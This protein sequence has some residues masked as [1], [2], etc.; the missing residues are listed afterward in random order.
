MRGI[1]LGLFV[2]VLI[3][4]G[5]AAGLRFYRG[6]REYRFLLFLFGC[7]V[8]LYALLFAVLPGDLGFLR[9]PWREP[10]SWVDFT[11]GLLVLSMLFHGFWGY[12]YASGIGPSASTMIEMGRRG[13]EMKY[14]ELRSFYAPDGSMDNVLARRLPKLLESGHVV[15]DGEG[16]RSQPSARK[17]ARIVL[18]LKRLFN[19]GAGG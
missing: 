13:G 11:S 8:F 19:T 9:R 15:R 10:A 6:R 2:F 5:A 16:F 14:G 3:V 12:C 4:A 1:L 7:G 17:Y 18:T